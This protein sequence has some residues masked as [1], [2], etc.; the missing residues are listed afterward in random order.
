MK[1][2]ESEG[3]FFEPSLFKHLFGGEDCRF[4]KLLDSNLFVEIVDSWP[5]ACF[6]NILVNMDFRVSLKEGVLITE[7]LLSPVYPNLRYMIGR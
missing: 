1:F 6:R 2:P 5:K 3:Y 7:Y 4:N